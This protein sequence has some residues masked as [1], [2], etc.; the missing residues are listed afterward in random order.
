[1]CACACVCVCVRARAQN[2]L[3]KQDF[4]LYR[5][6]NY[7]Y[8]ASAFFKSTE[9]VFLSKG[10]GS[11]E[12]KA[13]TSERFVCRQWSV[14]PTVPRTRKCHPFHASGAVHADLNELEGALAWWSDSNCPQWLSWQLGQIVEIGHKQLCRYQSVYRA[15]QCA[16][17]IWKAVCLGWLDAD[18]SVCEKNRLFWVLWECLYNES[19]CEKHRLCFGCS[20]NVFIMKVDVRSTDSAFWCSDNV[21]IWLQKRSVCSIQ[22]HFVCLSVF[23]SW[24]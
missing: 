10:T 16:P 23:C 2:S 7:H 9:F 8:L 6:F 15:F 19:G 21:S 12:A 22:R 1:M 20:E 18:E 17:F 14:L 4:V 5:C 11:A 13:I 24:G 3:C